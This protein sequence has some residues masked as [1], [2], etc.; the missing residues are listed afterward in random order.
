[1]KPSCSD[2]FKITPRA[3]IKF[4]KL[5]VF[6]TCIWLPTKNLN[7]NI[8]GVVFEIFWC[9]SLFFSLSLFIPLIVAINKFSDNTFTV[10]K[11]GILIGGII[12]FISKIIIIRNHREKFQKIDLELYEFLRSANKY[13]M[14]VL[15]R[16]V[17]KCWKFHGCMTCG[18][19]LTTVGVIIGPLFLPQKFPSDAIYP[20]P[21][22]SIITSTLVYLHHCI[23]GF[24]C[25]AALA[26]DYQ[27]AL[28]LC[29]GQELIQ[30]V[31]LVF[32]TRIF[33]SRVGITFGAIILLSDQ[34]IAV[35]LQFVILFVTLVISIFVCVWPAEILMNVSGNL[36]I[37]NIFHTS[38]THPPAIRKMWLNVIRRAQSP[39]TIKIDGFMDALSFEFYSAVQ[40]HI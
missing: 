40:Y 35:K 16:Y 11:S 33:V 29:S 25:S 38:S 15:Q 8:G 10:M 32:F 24:Q 6:L 2:R 39:I 19:Y 7:K 3:A 36:M 30:P 4:T 26:L 18:F 22:D 27:A 12:N 23:V 20:F 17:D 14:A 28:F 31:R 37:R 21:V 5:T 1:M 13:E 34:P 9:S